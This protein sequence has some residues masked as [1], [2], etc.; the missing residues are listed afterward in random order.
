MVT[1]NGTNMIMSLKKSSLLI[2]LLIPRPCKRCS[3]LSDPLTTW[4]VLERAFVLS[5]QQCWLTALSSWVSA[6][7]DIFAAQGLLRPRLYRFA[8][9]PELY[10]YD[11]D[12][13]L[14]IYEEISRKILD[15][16]DKRDGEELRKLISVAYVDSQQGVAICHDKVVVVGQ[17]PEEH[18]RGT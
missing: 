4:W 8:L 17:K 15:R 3:I 9:P 11:T 16:R 5:Q 12:N 1:F 14:S 7:G 6:L 2:Q 13:V 10:R 18:H